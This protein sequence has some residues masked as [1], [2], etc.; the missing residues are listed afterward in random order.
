MIKIPCENCITLSICIAKSKEIMLDTESVHSK[1]IKG[2][3]NKCKILEDYIFFNCAFTNE[4][5]ENVNKRQGTLKN[6]STKELLT[7]FGLNDGLYFVRNMQLQE[8]LEEEAK[9]K[10]E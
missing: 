9:H 1:F 7:F 8:Y 6:H 3:V 10:N 4:E 2:I 5:E